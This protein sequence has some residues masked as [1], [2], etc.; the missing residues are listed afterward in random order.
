M[1]AVWLTRLRWRMRGALLWPAFGVLTVLDAVLLERLPVYGTGP[2]G[3][4]PA[5]LLSASLNLV[6][7]AVLA[8]LGG[9]VLRRRRPDLPRAVAADFVGTALL[10]ALA[11]SLLIAG[12]GH[13]SA[14]LDERSAFYAQAAAASAYVEAHAPQYRAGLARMDSMRLRENYFRSCVPGDDPKRW[15]C[16]FVNTEQVPPRVVRDPETLPYPRTGLSG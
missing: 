14:V 6:C 10:S 13:R 5:L 2:H 11:L 7:V 12:I 16:V 15:L 9:R 3:T 8:P 1:D 4:V